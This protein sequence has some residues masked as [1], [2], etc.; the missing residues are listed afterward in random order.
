MVRTTAAMEHISEIICPTCGKTNRPNALACSRCNTLFFNPRQSTVSMRIDPR[1][2]RLRRRREEQLSEQEK[3][4]PDCS[5]LLHIR[6][7]VERL[8]FEQGTEVV[9]G[10]VDL[11]NPDPDRFDLT[12]FGGHERGVSRAH[13]VLRYN[14]KLLTVTDLGSVNGTS[15]NSEKLTPHMPRELK[16]NDQLTLGSLGISIRFEANTTPTAPLPDYLRD[17]A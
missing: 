17:E 1:I 7:L 6:G 8:I 11:A 14:D 4:A 12:R 10:R 2:L 15:V 9:L 5:V 16:H 3:L 13:A